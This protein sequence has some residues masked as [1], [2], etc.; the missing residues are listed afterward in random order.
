MAATSTDRATETTTAEALALS[1][2]PAMSLLPATTAMLRY[3]SARSF[4]DNY[5]SSEYA[6]PSTFF[7]VLLK[8]VRDEDYSS[9]GKCLW[10]NMAK[11]GMLVSILK[12]SKRVQNGLTIG[13]HFRPVWTPFR[14]EQE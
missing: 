6:I 13:D 3:L 4:S 10:Q 14:G 9:C 5:N 2:M 8:S 12:W 7:F 1:P 11:H